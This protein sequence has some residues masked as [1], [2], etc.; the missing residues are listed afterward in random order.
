[1]LTITFGAKR[2]R[3]FR[4]SDEVI[5]LVNR[6]PAFP[7]SE[8]SDAEPLSREKGFGVRGGSPLPRQLRRAPGRAFQRPDYAVPLLTFASDFA[9]LLFLID[10]PVISMRCA[11]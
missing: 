11:L 4:L 9:V 2:R 1:M 3:T 8:R 7:F 10:S 5:D 6:N